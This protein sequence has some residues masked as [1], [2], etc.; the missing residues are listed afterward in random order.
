MVL[1]FRFGDKE[2]CFFLPLMNTERADLRCFDLP[3]LH[4]VLSNSEDQLPQ[5]F[6][7]AH[8]DPNITQ[9]QVFL[10]LIVIK[11]QTKE[12]LNENFQLHKKNSFFLLAPLIFRWLFN[13]F[14][15]P[16]SRQ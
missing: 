9:I 11:L 14:A 7:A 12:F 8:K 6:S 13:L 5:R 2:P 16:E 10:L 15:S 1:E 3:S 4:L